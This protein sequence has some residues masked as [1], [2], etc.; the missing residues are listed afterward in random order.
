[1]VIRKC[2][3]VAGRVKLSQR[4]HS[5]PA[6]CAGRPLR[7]NYFRVQLQLGQP[8]PVSGYPQFCI[9]N[10]VGRLVICMI[11]LQHLVLTVGRAGQE[12]AT[13][14]AAGRCS[15]GSRYVYSTQ[16]VFGE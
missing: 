12:T 14:A 11:L 1:M 10:P 6:Q 7:T 16:S 3:G 15:A 4:T 13:A 5:G 8:V 2:V 9:L